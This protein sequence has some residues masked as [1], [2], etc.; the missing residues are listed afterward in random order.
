MAIPPIP[1]LNFDDEQLAI[2]DTTEFV[3]KMNSM[4][5]ELQAWAAA[6]NSY[7]TDVD[8]EL[9]EAKNQRLNLLPDHGTFLE[10]PGTISGGSDGFGSNN[11]LFRLDCMLAAFTNYN[12]TLLENSVEVGRFYNNSITLGGSEP[13]YN[14]IVELFIQKMGSEY[15]YAFPWAIIETM[16]GTGTAGGT[17]DGCYRYTNSGRVTRLGKNSSVSFSCWFQSVDFPA[18]L[19]TYPLTNDQNETYVDGVRIET[20]MGDNGTQWYRLEP[21]VVYHICHSYVSTNPNVHLSHTVPYLITRPSSKQRWACLW[22]APGMFQM[23][24]HLWPV[25][26]YGT[27]GNV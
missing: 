12:G 15:R 5:S 1:Q 23:K 8:A 17:H 9:I 3:N 22:A 13:A 25:R 19:L 11:A 27:V 21:N 10:F 20:S 26:S 14:S 24:P 4:M 6:V 18:Y 2:G 16:S 7:D